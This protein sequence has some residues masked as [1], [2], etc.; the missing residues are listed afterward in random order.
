[1]NDTSESSRRL[2]R[3]AH[4]G[5]MLA[6]V[7]SGLADYLAVDVTIVRIAFVVA[8]LLGG[9]GVPAYL[10]CLLLIPEEG[11][12]VSLAADLLDSIQSR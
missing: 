12:D 9:V 4:H 11:L 2:L 7:A 5:R 1:M 3:R 10:A 6:G 8:T